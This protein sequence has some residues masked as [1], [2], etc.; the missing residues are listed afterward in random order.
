MSNKDLKAKALELKKQGLS[1]QQIA[2]ELGV[3]K[4][5]VYNWIL[6]AQDN[7][8]NNSD[9]VFSPDQ[10][11][12]DELKRE[13]AEL[14]IEISEGANNGEDVSHLLEFRRLEMEHEYRMEELE[15]NRRDNLFQQEIKVLKRQNEQQ[16]HNYERSLNEVQKLSDLNSEMKSNLERLQKHNSELEDEVFMLEDSTTEHSEDSEDVS[17]PQS[18]VESLKELLEE[19]LEFDGADCTLESIEL[20]NDQVHEL[21]SEIEGWVKTNDFNIDGEGAMVILEKFNDDVEEALASFENEDADELTL[22][23]DEDWKEEVEEWLS[24]FL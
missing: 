18:F 23:F 16:Q 8:E 12:L 5:T 7:S 17:F 20:I 15:S 6:Y 22:V 24:D 2:D 13:L 11:K 3:G 14:R 21:R 19:Y 9:S 4:T 10:E 1:Y